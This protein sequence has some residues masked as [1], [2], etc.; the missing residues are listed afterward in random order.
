MCDAAYEK[1]LGKHVQGLEMNWR[2]HHQMELYQCIK[3]LNVEETRKISSQFIRDKEGRMPRD[4]R[5][6]PGRWV[7]FFD[8]LLNANSDKL[9]LDIIEGLPQRPVT[10]TLGVEPT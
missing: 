7:W 5:L 8:T 10:H 3:S 9:R 4:P 2:Q 1:F 6:V